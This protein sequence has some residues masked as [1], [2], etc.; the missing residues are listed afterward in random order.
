[1]SLKYVSIE[2]LCHA[3]IINSNWLIIAMFL[4]TSNQSV[5]ISAKRS[6]TA[7]KYVYNIGS[8]FQIIMQFLFFQLR[9]FLAMGEKEF[10]LIKSIQPGTNATAVFSFVRLYKISKILYLNFDKNRHHGKFDT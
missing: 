6:Y 5:H 10:Y 2:K 1:M 8:C 3:K 9:H 4:E 7:L